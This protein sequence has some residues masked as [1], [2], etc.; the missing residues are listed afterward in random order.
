M[1]VSIPE[2]F[3]LGPGFTL[4][5][6]EFLFPPYAAIY[7]DGTVVH[8]GRS[9]CLSPPALSGA[10]SVAIDWGA[11]GFECL[12]LGICLGV[13]YRLLSRAAPLWARD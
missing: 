12:V 4:L 2:Y 3:L 1:D 9:I 10:L 6:L 13:S 11:L 7:S 8:L 5:I